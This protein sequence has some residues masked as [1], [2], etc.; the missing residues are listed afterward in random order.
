MEKRN[1][2]AK[3]LI[4]LAVVIL[5]I[6]LLGGVVGG[7]DLVFHLDRTALLTRS[8]VTYKT[9]DAPAASSKDGTINAS[10]WAALYPEIVATMG[11][12]K[13]NSYIVDYLEQD[14]YL[15]NIYEGFG[16]AKE[17]GSARGHEYTLEDVAKT[18]RPHPL[19]NCLT[20]KTPNF[21][22]LVNDQGVSAYTMSFDDAMALMEENVSCYT[23]HGNE[24]GNKGQLV[25]THSYVTKALGS[26]A[27]AI[28]PATLSCGQCHIEYYF[29]P[30]DK[31]T[32]MPYGS[33][34]E[35]TPEAILAYY[36]TMVLPDGTVGFSDFVQPSTGTKMLKAQHP[37]METY[38]TGKHAKLLNCADCHMPLEETAD[39]TVYHS[40]ELVSPL[41][42]ETLLKSCAT[43][44]GDKDMV[45]MVR[46]LQERVTARETEVGN[47]L[48][49]F[50][51]ALA[52]AVTNGKMTEE[53]LDAVRKL[54]RE[55]QW[56]FDFCYV[57]NAEGAHNSEL[58]TRCLDT[59]EARINE[60][61]ALLGK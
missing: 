12:N 9:V 14:P 53:E 10:D 58:A 50:K 34:E 6:L 46:R 40:H 20:C 18:A 31:E 30:T 47:K 38:L 22:K 17:Y 29:T 11:D 8:D 55:A 15:K 45:T 35:M 24:A 7:K 1:Q 52:E 33:V 23:C 42:N 32:M 4:G 25:V 54:H 43:C 13:K 36:D 56:F 28:D 48:S 19:A 57:E 5:A 44:H 27:E 51:D 39:G 21:A 2:A 16:F 49:A 3:L 26:N 59:A 61:M 41:E 60:G 37:E